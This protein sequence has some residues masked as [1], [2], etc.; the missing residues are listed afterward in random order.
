MRRAL[1][2]LVGLVYAFTGETH[3]Q[4]V[5]K[6]PEPYEM[7]R[8][9]QVLQAQITEGNGPAVG[10]QRALLAEMEKRFL[11]AA[12]ATWQDVRNGRAAVIYTLSGG[13]PVVM[14]HLASLDPRPQIDEDLALGAL[15]YIEGRHKEAREHLMKLNARA[16]PPSLGGQ[17]ALV[18]AGLIAQDDLKRAIALLDDARLLMPGT[19]V[20]EAALRREVFMV[21]QAGDIERFEYLSGHYLRRFNNSVYAPDFRQ[22]F[23]TALTRLNLAETSGHFQRLRALLD[24]SDTDNRRATFLHVARSA[25]IHGKIETARLAAAQAESLS[26]LGSSDGVRARLY[27]AAAGIVTEDFLRHSDDLNVTNRRQLTEADNALLDAAQS[28]AAAIRYWPSIEGERQDIPALRADKARADW[29][30][31]L[32][33]R[34]DADLKIAQKLLQEAPTK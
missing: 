14:R 29:A 3:A 20:D 26:M 27:G 23:A 11:A 19:L 17:I 33:Q 24:A 22:R 8:T 4:T 18:Q 16:L 21:A 2:A 5:D 1:A 34:A 10:A 32:M 12:P 28:T 7:A 13:N 30:T 31:D 9:L 6:I 25:T 15:A